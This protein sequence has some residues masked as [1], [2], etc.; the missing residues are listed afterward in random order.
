MIKGT[1]TLNSVV[2]NQLNLETNICPFRGTQRPFTSGVGDEAKG[3]LPTK[4]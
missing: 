1:I 3:Q 4:K 2:Q